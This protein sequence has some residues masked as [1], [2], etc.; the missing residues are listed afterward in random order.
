MI[1]ITD[2]DRMVIIN[3]R[4]CRKLEGGVVTSFNSFNVV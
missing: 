2:R 4:R 3:D 1:P